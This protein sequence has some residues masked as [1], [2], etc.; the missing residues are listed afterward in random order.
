MSL[1]LAWMTK[2]DVQI[3][4]SQPRDHKFTSLIQWSNVTLEILWKWFEIKATRCTQKYNSHS[5]WSIFRY[6]LHE[7]DTKMLRA[8][9]FLLDG[10]PLAFW[11]IFLTVHRYQFKLFIFLGGERHCGVEFSEVQNTMTQPGFNGYDPTSNTREI[12]SVILNVR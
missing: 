2:I 4:R 9:G 10:L 7:D 8:S 6:L 1:S 12:S 3:A 5:Y 11:Q